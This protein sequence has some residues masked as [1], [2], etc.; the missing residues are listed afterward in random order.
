MTGTGP[1]GWGAGGAAA[2]P[3]WASL[4]EAAAQEERDRD[5]GGESEG[6]DDEEEEEEDE[7]EEEVA[8]RAE[9]GGGRDEDEDEGSAGRRETASAGR[10]IS[11]LPVAV[12]LPSLMKRAWQR[13]H[14]WGRRPGQAVSSAEVQ[15][16][17]RCVRTMWSTTFS[18]TS[19]NW[20]PDAG[21][22]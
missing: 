4:T 2:D 22:K 3:C 13:G 21:Q 5:A 16:I 17:F 9:E 11:H 1:D 20:Q 14:A 6:A 10:R 7:E 18:T 12:C 19:W 8:G 15:I